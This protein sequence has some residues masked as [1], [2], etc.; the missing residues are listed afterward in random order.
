[1]TMQDR[2]AA[3]LAREIQHA[4][5][6][7]GF[8]PVFQPIARLSD[9]ALA[10]FEALARWRRED[11]SLSGPGQFLPTALTHELMGAV[12]QRIL[13]QSVAILAQWRAAAPEAQGLFLTVNVPGGDLEKGRIV[14]EAIELAQA[15]RLPAGAL[16]IEVTE[17]QILKD[18]AA[19]AAA[20]SRLRRAGLAVAFDDFG[21]GFA[22][23]AWLA[24]L[25]V[26]TLKVDRSFTR[27]MAQPRT[28][29]IVRAVVALAHELGLDVVAEGVETPDVRDRLTDFGC[30]YAQ[31]HLFAPPLSSGGAEALIRTLASADPLVRLT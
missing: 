4:I 12:S 29:K 10:G 6:H 13:R 16:K 14:D 8:E 3:A 23:L 26:D 9:G 30:D 20:L 25:P 31:G 1:M 19:A 7:G 21:A 5:D 2:S 17:H 18:P 24:R 27:D 11:G 22:S 28:E 15:A